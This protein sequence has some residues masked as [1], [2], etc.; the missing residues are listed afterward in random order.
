MNSLISIRTN[1]FY[2][3]K[4]DDTFAKHYELVFLLEKASYR[5]TN[6]EEVIRE[7]GIEEMRFTVS[8]SNFDTM[9]K[10]LEQLKNCKES[11]LK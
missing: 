9:L 7:R 2:T 6:E 10:L 5:Y 3:K 4:K 1:F 11:D 8:E